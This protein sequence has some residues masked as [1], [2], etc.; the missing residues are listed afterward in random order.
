MTR[1]SEQA[2]IGLGRG[3]RHGRPRQVG[4][5]RQVEPRWPALDP[6]QH[7]VLD[8]VKADRAA[9]D[10]LSDAGQHVLGAEYLQQPQDLD[11]LAFAALGYAG[12]DQAT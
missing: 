5:D 6:A 3:H 2:E 8:R 7:Q 10:G 4:I 9:G 1:A 12:L 11:E